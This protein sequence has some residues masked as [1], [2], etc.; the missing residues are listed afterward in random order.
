[1]WLILTVILLILFLCLYKL[2]ENYY[3]LSLCKRV[4]SVDGGKLEDK[5]CVVPGASKLFGN[6]FDLLKLTPGK[7]PHFKQNLFAM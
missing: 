1:M 7:L 6:N 2:N 3:V 4:K 5:I